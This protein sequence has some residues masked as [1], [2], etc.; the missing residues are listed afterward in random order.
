M[1]EGRWRRETRRGRKGN[2]SQGVIYK[3]IKFFRKRILIC[4]EKGKQMVREM[5]D[6]RPDKDA[7]VRCK[8]NNEWLETRS[9]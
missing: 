7:E 2:F 9:Q 5:K 1:G 4:Q 6:P 8:D 3:R